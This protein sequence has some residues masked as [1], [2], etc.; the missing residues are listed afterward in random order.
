MQKIRNKI[1]FFTIMLVGAILLIMYLVQVPFLEIVYQHNKAKDVRNIQVEMVQKFNEMDVE[2][3]YRAI[4]EIAK[5][6]ELYIAIYDENRREVMSPFS[7]AQRKDIPFTFNPSYTEDYRYVLN[8][9]IDSLEQT[10]KSTYVHYSDDGK[11]MVMVSRIYASD[12]I[13]YFLTRA[14]LVPV[15]ATSDIIKKNFL[16]VLVISFAFACIVAFI[17]A[18][19]ISKPVRALSKGAK[20]V[21]AGDLSYRIPEPANESEIANLIRDFNSMT[22]ELSKVDMLRKDLIANVSHELRTPLTMIK[23]YAETVRDLTGDNPEK[24]NKQLAVIIEETDR[25][26][27]LIASLL[28][29]SRMQN[30]QVEFKTEQIN[31][32]DTVRSITERYACFKDR[33]Y[34]ID[35]SLSDNVYVTGDESRLEQVVYN[36]MDNAINHSGEAQHV[37]VILTGGEKP[38]FS[39]INSGPAISEEDIQYIWDRF[40]HVDKSGKRR[41]S[42]TGIGLSLVREILVHH[43]FLYGVNS[44]PGRT[45]FWFEPERKED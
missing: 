12:G 24:R 11:K 18:Q 27:D 32:S 22:V 42:G 4:L 13:F 14:P 36:L 20:A 33:G 43:K 40:Y 25:L 23:G 38:R 28:D 9:A 2:S 3:A 17:L 15:K 5:E 30:G 19:H 31:F 1:F 39:V 35:V 41:V 21:A 45:E 10:G 6:N 37:A 26:T 34:R 44:M 7:F 8:R 29:L 16:W